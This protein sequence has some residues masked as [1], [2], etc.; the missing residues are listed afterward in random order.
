MPRPA[1]PSADA[2]LLRL[3]GLRSLVIL[4]L[5]VHFTDSVTFQP[6]MRGVMLGVQLCAFALV[7]VAAL[8]TPAGHGRPVTA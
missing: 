6:L 4:V 8:V 7:A 1:R 2:R 3:D 5:L